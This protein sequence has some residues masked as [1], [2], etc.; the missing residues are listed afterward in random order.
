MRGKIDQGVFSTA[1]VNQGVFATEGRI[2]PTLVKATERRA[3]SIWHDCLKDRHFKMPLIKAVGEAISKLSDRDRERV[4]LVSVLSEME[5]TR[6]RNAAIN[7][8]KVS[9]E[10]RQKLLGLPKEEKPKSLIQELLHI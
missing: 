9:N 10:S 4:D 3:W 2:D 6:N 1:N 8:G 5:R 7:R